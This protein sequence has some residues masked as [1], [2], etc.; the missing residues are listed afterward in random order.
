MLF[1]MSIKSAIVLKPFEKYLTVRK[2]HS[3]KL[4]LSFNCSVEPAA[5]AYFVGTRRDDLAIH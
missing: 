2:Y 3:G 1:F 4:P 5:F